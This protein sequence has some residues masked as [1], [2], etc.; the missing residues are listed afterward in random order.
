MRIEYM[1][2]IL[3]SGFYGEYNQ[4][5]MSM[6]DKK[7]AL[8]FSNVDESHLG[9]DVFLVPYYW[10]K[11]VGASG[12]IVYP[13]KKAHA[14]LPPKY[15]GICLE[16]LREYLKRSKKSYWISALVY[17]LR[18]AHKIDILM[19]FHFSDNTLYIGNFYKLLHPKGFLYIKCDGEIWLDHFLKILEEGRGFKGVWKRFL[20]TRLLKKADLI[21]IETVTG[22]EKMQT[23]KYCGVSLKNK[24]ALLSN[25]FDEDML[26]SFSI[27]ERKCVE[28][29]N[30]IIS[31][32]RLG[33]YEKNTEMILD[34]AENVNFDD[35][36][37]VLIGPVEPNLKELIEE[38]Y[39][40]NPHLKNSVIFTGPIYDKKELWEWYNRSK[41]FLLTSREESFAL[42]LM[43]A[44]RFNN[45]I[46]STDVG[47]ARTAIDQSM[48]EIIP[49][50]DS[51]ALKRSL[52]RIINGSVTIFN[53]HY[54]KIDVSYE[55]AV[56][57][58][59]K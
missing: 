7:F 27:K 41:V 37:L 25:G 51:S 36:K 16:P 53:D 55:A 8:I 19:Q 57:N 39:I 10:C 29:E 40:N 48:G 20:V 46:V 32:G 30:L 35:W 45:Y 12:V 26:H 38:F 43:E 28:K 34:A 24:S 47:W 42:V 2:S 5:E 31:V 1:G 50:D 17:L 22:Y 49:Q 54:H 52:Q 6:K 15:R 18:E 33:T 4:K 13:R 23:R 44:Y 14:E 9:K 59:L 11:V 21:S 3:T 58:V 56:R